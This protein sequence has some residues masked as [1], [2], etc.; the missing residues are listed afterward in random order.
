[1]APVSCRTAA[2]PPPPPLVLFANI[3]TTTYSI[4]RIR[5]TY[6]GERQY[7]KDTAQNNTVMHRDRRCQ[8]YGHNSQFVGRENSQVLKSL[9]IAATSVVWWCFKN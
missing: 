2:A 4:Q 6:F 8:I 1:M 7:K 3:I 9:S 5:N